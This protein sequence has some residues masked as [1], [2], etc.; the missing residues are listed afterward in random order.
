M[1]L[2][3]RFNDARGAILIGM[4]YIAVKTI[5]AAR[6][7]TEKLRRLPAQLDVYLPDLIAISFN[8]AI[9]AQ[10]RAKEKLFAR[11]MD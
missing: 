8:T 6:H 2:L 10:S 7:G 11:R 5:D 1:T 3:A 9:T 4:I